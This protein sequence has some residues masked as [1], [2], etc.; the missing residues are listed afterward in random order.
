MKARKKKSVQ[1]LREAVERKYLEA[2]L[3]WMDTFVDPRDR[4]LDEVTGE[5]WRPIGS[6]DSLE[7]E[8]EP[9]TNE[10]ELGCIRRK[11]RSICRRNS[12][13]ENFLVNMVSFTVGSGH[14][15]CCEPL[16]TQ[17][18]NH[19]AKEYARKLQRYIDRLLKLNR[20]HKR[21]QEIVRRR[22]RDGEAFIRIF[23]QSNGYCLFR[24]VEPV[25]VSTPQKWMSDPSASF[26][27][28]TDAQDVETVEWYFVGEEEVEPHEMQHRKA[29]VD[30][31]SKRGL[32]S[33]YC[34]GANLD[35]G[36]KLL[37][38]M[39]TLVQIQSAIAMIRKH[40]KTSGAVKSFASRNA[41]LQTTNSV[42]GETRN[43]K[44]YRAGTILD[45][46]EG[47]EHEF[48]SVGLNPG[49]PVSVL[50]AELRAV[51][52]S[53]ALP[54]YMVGSDASNANYSST[55]VAE[56][57]AV[58][59]FEAE[60]SEQI[61]ADLE[62][63][64]TSVQYAVDAGLLPADIKKFVE[65]NVEAPNLIARQ[66]NE[67]ANA[68]EIYM[69]N[70]VMSPQTVAGRLGLDAGQEQRNWAEFDDAS[71][72]QVALPMPGAVDGTI[73]S[74]GE[75]EPAALLSMAGGITGAVEIMKAVK[76]QTI[77]R[78]SAI[79]MFM[80]FYRLEEEAAVKLVGMQGLSRPRSIGES[81]RA[82]RKKR[83]V[84]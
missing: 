14:K 37:K 44:P 23:P 7:E 81:L 12:Y 83:K 39:S 33:L 65:I 3:S 31:N 66:V 36:E 27:I 60:Q 78:E 62:L 38:N 17:R 25:E 79:Q 61:E 29:N 40:K 16:K 11:A 63:I 75:T 13:A 26:G 77:S 82:R 2:Q 15:Y 5:R 32:S 19:T 35:R 42:T 49:A 4:Y 74:G 24:F 54:E 53:K 48:P 68:D 56:S 55:M 20:W 6:Y 1:S 57:P 58:R 64:W 69:R 73:P 70:R 47:V 71:P 22:H 84:A 51:A 18:R 52:A 34:V 28:K 50:G 9:F 10:E 21:Q 41:A 76:E 30:M 59:F 46:K 45:T 80:M 67:Q 72:D 8:V 43:F